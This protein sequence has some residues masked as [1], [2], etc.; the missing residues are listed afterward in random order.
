M[1]KTTTIQPSQG[2][3]QQQQEFRILHLDPLLASLPNAAFLSGSCAP[4][5]VD[6]VL[7]PSTGL[8]DPSKG[9]LHA[10]SAILLPAVSRI[11]E[12]KN[13]A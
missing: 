1:S 2:N 13:S 3:S 12:S 4:M 7:V 8:V 6:N 11:F 9:L 5:A 10:N